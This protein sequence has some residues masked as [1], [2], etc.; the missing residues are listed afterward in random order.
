MRQT[1]SIHDHR[2]HG[3]ARNV[4][5][6]QGP[7]WLNLVACMGSEPSLEMC[8]NICDMTA[9]TCTFDDQQRG[10]AGDAW[11][12]CQDDGACT[13]FADTLHVMWC[14]DMMCCGV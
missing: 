3:G 5:G 4:P 10:H 8:S 12:V 11:V 2:E 13:Y 6:T 9:W 7:I 14:H 1:H